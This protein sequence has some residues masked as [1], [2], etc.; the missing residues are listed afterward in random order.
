[1]PTEKECKDKGKILNPI[2]G[3][4]I[5][6]DTK[7]GKEILAAKK[8]AKKKSP[9]K[10]RSRGRSRSKS[11]SKSPKGKRRSRSKSKSP[12]KKGKVDCEK[13][14]KIYNPD[15]GRCVGKDTKKGKEIL[16]RGRSKSP[17]K[18]PKGS[19]KKKS[20]KEEKGCYFPEKCSVSKDFSAA[21]I[22]KIAEDCGINIYKKE[23]SKAKKSRKDLCEEI[24]KKSPKKSPKGS[25]RKT[26]PKKSP[27][28]ATPKGS[29]RK[30]K[31]ELTKMTI[32]AL[33]ELAKNKGI[34]GYSG[35]KK[36]DLVDHIYANLP[37]SPKKSPKKATPKKS[38]KK[39][40]PIISEES[41]EEFFADEPVIPVKSE[42]EEEI[43]QYSDTEYLMEDQQSE[44]EE[45]KRL[46]E[47]QKIPTPKVSPKKSPKGSPRKPTP[48]KTP[49][50]SPK[51][52]KLFQLRNELKSKG[53]MVNNDASEEELEEIM[54]SDCD[55]D[56]YSCTDGKMCFVNDSGQGKCIPPGKYSKGMKGSPI[57]E[58]N[59]KGKTFIGSEKAIENL[60]A[61]MEPVPEKKLPKE[62]IEDLLREI[63]EPTEDTES[64]T[65]VR[66]HLYKCLGLI[67]E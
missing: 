37:K 54:N 29:P 18:S 23:G 12:V 61:K 34:K 39:P 59:F 32:K 56:N 38:P 60:K 5:G 19:P 21:D 33:Q 66:E 55:A 27:K 58:Y 35:K 63:K 14:G 47:E 20:P 49:K 4:C 10:R 28:K 36:Q 51:K 45:L 2:S 57:K 15:S 6:K 7:K 13:I 24:E 44:K 22:Q 25:P 48:K 42:S 40:T 9:V 46:K 8:A 53:I 62:D 31:D 65:K 16:S 11:R 30:S 26:S 50:K 3:R 17:K 43:Y 41:D 1:M 52:S 67:S 64:L